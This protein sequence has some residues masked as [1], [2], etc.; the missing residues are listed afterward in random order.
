[1]RSGPSAPLLVAWLA[2][3]FAPLLGMK[4]LRE[5]AA[6]KH[7]RDVAGQVH[8]AVQVARHR[9]RFSGLPHSI[10]FSESRTPAWFEIRV[11]SEDLLVVPSRPLPC[12]RCVGRVIPVPRTLFHEDVVFDPAPG[13]FCFGDAVD[14]RIIASWNCGTCNLVDFNHDY[15]SNPNYVDIRIRDDPRRI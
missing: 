6:R 1:M 11:R 3:T 14:P 9:S 15:R 12:H 7:L 4:Q 10:V 8:E 5:F 2:F 13:S